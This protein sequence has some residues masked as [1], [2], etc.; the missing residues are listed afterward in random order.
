M[1]ESCEID[2]GSAVH[3]FCVSWFANRVCSVGT[4]LAIQA[5]NDHPVPSIYNTCN[6]SVLLFNPLIR[7]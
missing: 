7:P 1:E 4:T 2:M 6:S 5:W 3:K